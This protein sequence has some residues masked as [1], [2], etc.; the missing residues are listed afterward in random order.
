MSLKVL[1]G[2]QRER[3]LPRSFCDLTTLGAMP[4]MCIA[5]PGAGDLM[6]T[7]AG[8]FFTLMRLPAWEGRQISNPDKQ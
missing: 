4:T 3:D 1:K 2:D 8:K 6:M 5:V 7:K